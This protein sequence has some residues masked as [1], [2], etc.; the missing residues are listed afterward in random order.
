MQARSSCA[1]GSDRTSGALTI[2]ASILVQL[3]RAAIVQQ[4]QKTIGHAH[5]P[6]GGAQS[7]RDVAR[8]GCE[9]TELVRDRER[10]RD[11]KQEQSGQAAKSTRV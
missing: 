6:T 8:K 1:P 5:R 7:T 10:E 4:L 11:E 2:R 9:L 3:R